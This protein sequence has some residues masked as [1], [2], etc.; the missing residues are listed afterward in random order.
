MEDNN[1]MKYWDKD[2]EAKVKA[3]GYEFLLL[4]TRQYLARYA[5]GLVGE[6]VLPKSKYRHWQH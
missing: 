6:K 2:Y 1:I 3:D 4:C 5:P